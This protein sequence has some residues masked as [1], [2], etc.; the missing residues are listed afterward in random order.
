MIK[1]KIPIVLQCTFRKNYTDI[2]SSSLINY[3]TNSVN[4]ILNN[5]NSATSQ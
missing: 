2:L 3:I 4:Y 5:S 1:L